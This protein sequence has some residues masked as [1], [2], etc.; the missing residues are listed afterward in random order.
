[1]ARRSRSQITRELA[2]KIAQ[3]LEAVAITTRSDEHDEYGVYH[4]G[5]LVA[6]FGIRRSSRKSIGHDYIPN[7][8]GVGPNFAKQLGWC[9]KQRV[10]YLREIGEMPPEA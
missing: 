9:P 7:E 5:A 3:K 4:E 2:L 8:L 10:D 6:S 1:M